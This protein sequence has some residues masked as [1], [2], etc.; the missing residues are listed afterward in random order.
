M[1]P[2]KTQGRRLTRGTVKW[3]WTPAGRGPKRKRVKLWF[4]R[5]RAEFIDQDTGAI[6]R[7]P[8]RMRIDGA[9]RSLAAASQALDE[10]LALQAPDE[11]APGTAVTV[12]EYCGFFDRRR[13]AGMSTSSQRRYRGNHRR[14]ILPFFG[15]RKLASIRVS[16]VEEFAVHLH[17]Q[18]KLSRASI[19]GCIDQLLQMFRHAR[20]AGYAVHIVPRS[21]VKPPR[22]AKPPREPRHFLQSEID[23][24]IAAEEKPARRALWMLLALTGVR[25]GEALGLPWSNVDLVAGVIRI[26]QGC[27]AGAIVKEDLKTARSK[28]I[29]PMLPQL[30]RELAAFQRIHVSNPEQLLFASSAGTPL[31][32]DD[33]CR[34]WLKPLLLRL[35]IPH[36][37]AHAFR[38]YTPG[39]LDAIGL[40]PAAIQKW[41][42]HAQL[43]MTERYLHHHD[44]DLRSQLARALALHPA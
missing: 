27:V 39:M 6:S 17:K 37:G 41:L 44:E 23:Q 34:R 1:S 12:R 7:G 8:A 21:S 35:Q 4:N 25:I 28:R 42:G 22:E 10:Y 5:Y 26:R 9:F 15:G 31:R 16:D 14:Y 38:H 29:V 24:I 13:I 2:N 20:R 36:A 43:A 18:H 32:S 40:R 30:R 3:K 19:G 33:V 11:L